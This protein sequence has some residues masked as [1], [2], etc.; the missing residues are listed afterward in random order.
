VLFW[1]T[2]VKLEASRTFSKKISSSNINKELTRKYIEQHKK[3]KA[4]NPNQYLKYTALKFTKISYFIDSFIVGRKIA[5]FLPRAII[6][7]VVKYLIYFEYLVQK[8]FPSNRLN[9][10]F[11]NTKKIPRLNY[12]NVYNIKSFRK[13]SLRAYVEKKKISTENLSIL[14]K[15]RQS[16]KS[17]IFSL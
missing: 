8:M 4:G 2:L 9:N 10:L 7:P 3:I 15:I 12:K 6:Y 13:K 16:L 1:E 11:T 14:E 17:R 5:D